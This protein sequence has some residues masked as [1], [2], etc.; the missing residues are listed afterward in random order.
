[1][2]KKF[3]II[4]P[5][6]KVEKYLRKCVDSILEQSYKNYELILVDD[7]SP[8]NCPQICDEYAK[9][10]SRVR[11]IHKKNG[12]LV[13]ARNT[14]VLAATGEYICYVDGDDWISKELLQITMDKAISKYEPD[15]V[16]F[17]AVRQ[18]ED[19]Q[20]EIPKGAIEG[21]YNK[22]KLEKDV[23]P[24]MMYDCR[25]PFCTGL[26]F[27]VAWNK[28]FKRELL[29]KHYCTEERIRMGEDNAFVFECLYY[30]NNV[31][32]CEDVLYY[33]NQL[34]MGSMTNNY[35]PTRFE[36]NRL[37][38]EYIDSKIGGKN[39]IIDAQ[40]N[41]FKAYWLIMAVFHEIKSNQP[42][43]KST[44]HIRKNIR[45]NNTLKGIKLKGLP[46]SAQAFIILLKCNFIFTSLVLAKFVN[47]KRKAN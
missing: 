22:E 26:I 2:S 35:D 6:Y 18:F 23:Y 30:S 28:I 4:V 25:K 11:V 29:T 33:Y 39:N 40:I 17:S 3:S 44:K 36:N 24:Y 32:F 41:A 45:D 27:P 8:D 21:F 42:I 7:G 38:T 15:M 1:M 37:L 43:L 46:K 10:D 13:A 31:Y 9:K 5:I 20:V 34:N 12:G 16:V 14:G 47:K 19:K